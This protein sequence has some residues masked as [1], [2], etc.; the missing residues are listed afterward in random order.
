MNEEQLKKHKNMVHAL[1]KELEG[2]GHMHGIVLELITKL[3]K[4]VRE[5][6]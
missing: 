1:A 2:R 3:L 6:K 4:S 5:A